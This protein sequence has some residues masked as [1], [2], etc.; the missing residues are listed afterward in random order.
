MEIILKRLHSS[1]DFSTTCHLPDLAPPCRPYGRQLC[2]RVTTG[3]CTSASHPTPPPCLQLA[4]RQPPPLPLVIR[5]TLWPPCSD[6]GLGD[7][8]ATCVT[9]GSPCRWVGHGSLPLGPESR[10]VTGAGGLPSWGLWSKTRCFFWACLR[11]G[12]LDQDRLPTA[13]AVPL[14]GL[15]T[16]TRPPLFQ[17]PFH[18]HPQ[19]CDFPKERTIGRGTRTL[20]SFCFCCKVLR[21]SAERR[22]AGPRFQAGERCAQ[23]QRVNTTT[24]SVSRALCLPKA[25][26]S[27]PPKDKST[28]N[29][30]AE[31]A[32]PDFSLCTAGMVAP[33]GPR[34]L[35]CW[36]DMQTLTRL[37]DSEGA[38]RERV[39]TAFTTDREVTSA[40]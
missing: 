4:L 13:E 37:C 22:Q 8:M 31:R 24:S 3:C 39:C 38:M 25:S 20:S 35:I 36:V 33:A 23:G 1:S 7:L 6:G 34:L 9:T 30:T 16:E 32:A 2:H 10:C 19:K 28:L 18:K 15:P 21:D 14:G 26:R 12:C 27:P 17:K 40:K 29:L 5:G 11:L